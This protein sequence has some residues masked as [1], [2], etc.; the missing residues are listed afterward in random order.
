[1]IKL[2]DILKEAVGNYNRFPLNVLVKHAKHFQDFKDFSRFFSIQI[3]H[4]YYWH[5]TEDPNFKP[6]SEISPRDMSSMGSGKGGSKGLMITSDIEN[7]LGNYKSTRGYAALLDTSDVEPTYLKQVSR[8][9]GNEIFI[10]ENQVNNIKVV[11][12]FPLSSVKRKERELE[13]QMP[14]SEEELKQ[15]YNFAQGK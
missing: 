12:V 10:P 9:F 14:R 3:G 11:K 1:M 15:L 13:K 2:K 4:G 8:G 5:I 7:W 6:S